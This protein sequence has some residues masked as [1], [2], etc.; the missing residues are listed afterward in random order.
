MIQFKILFEDEPGKPQEMIV[1]GWTG[2][3]ISVLSKTLRCLLWGRDYYLDTLEV[4]NVTET[5]SK[6]EIILGADIDFQG[7]EIMERIPIMEVTWE[8]RTRWF[9]ESPE[10]RKEIAESFGI[11]N[12][13]W[14]LAHTDQKWADAPVEIEII[15]ETSSDESTEDSPLGKN[16]DSLALLFIDFDEEGNVQ[17][18]IEIKEEETS[19]GKSPTDQNISREEEDEEEKSEEIAKEES[20]ET[21]P[22]RPGEKR[23]SIDHQGKIYQISCTSE[24]EFWEK[25]KR[26][27][28]VRGKTRI[29]DEENHELFFGELEDKGQH[30]VSHI[31]RRIYAQITEEEHEASK[32]HVIVQW[33]GESRTFGFSQ[34]WDLWTGLKR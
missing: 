20:L 7:D 27:F 31:D 15:E 8:D 18:R 16:A 32:T 10:W 21:P 3:H 33:Q 5:G 17:S 1:H 13:N 4:K 9:R 12:L 29:T 30:R 28:R 14:R 34:N 26:S 2:T 6:A 24:K 25:I 11:E 19:M 22:I 23:L